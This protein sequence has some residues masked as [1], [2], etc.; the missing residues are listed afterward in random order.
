MGSSCDNKT[1]IKIKK[2]PTRLL[3][4]KIWLSKNQAE[5][6]AKTPSNEKN[7]CCGCGC[8]IF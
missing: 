5:T 7:Y 8:N 2:H 1:P 3:I 6:V 4:S